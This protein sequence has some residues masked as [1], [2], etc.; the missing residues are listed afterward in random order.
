[1]KPPPGWRFGARAILPSAVLVIFVTLFTHA[2]CAAASGRSSRTK[3]L[4][5]MRIERTK[6][7]MYS[8]L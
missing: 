6:L 1:M 7:A 4:A 3:A 8:G 5:R 2:C